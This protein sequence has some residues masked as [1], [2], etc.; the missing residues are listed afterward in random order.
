MQMNEMNAKELE[1]LQ[2]IAERRILECADIITSTLS[3][4]YTNQMESIFG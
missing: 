4:C 2:R 1:K 3:S